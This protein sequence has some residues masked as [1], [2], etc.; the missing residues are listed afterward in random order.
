MLFRKALF[1]IVILLFPMVAAAQN[2]LRPFLRYRSSFFNS[3]WTLGA[4]IG[5]STY[6]GHIDSQFPDA[7]P[8][9]WKSEID[10]SI[11][12][13]L[14]YR[15]KPAWGIEAS[16]LTTRLTGTQKDSTSRL[17]ILNPFPYKP[18]EVATFKTGVTTYSLSLV[19]YIN[20]LLAPDNWKTRYEVYI[21]AG[22]GQITLNSMEYLY[23]LT[24]NRRKMVYPF[25]LGGVWH[26]DKQW[27]A[28]VE[29]RWSLTNTDRLDGTHDI[30][31]D[32]QI[33]YKA[34][35]HFATIQFTISY[36]FARNSRAR[37]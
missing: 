32:G 1:L 28:G 33:Y 20:R 37:F 2:Y 13:F 11:G 30:A 25:S 3:Y 10:P 35:E 21:K 4:D 14:Q 18:I 16:L 12:F 8:H 24:D 22:V 7:L 6:T 31:S 9:P 36:K 26:L 34:K 29:A 27:D 5:V 17:S 23:I 19:A 15:F